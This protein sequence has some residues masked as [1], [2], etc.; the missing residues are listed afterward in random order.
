LGNGTQTEG[1]IVKRQTIM[2]L[3]GLI[4]LA[5]CSL[6]VYK[7]DIRPVYPEL[8]YGVRPTVVDSLTPTFRWQYDMTTPCTYDF[9]IWD[10]GDVTAWGTGSRME[11]RPYIYYK[12]ALTQPEHKIELPLAPDTLYYWSVRT[13]SGNVV[14][15]WATHDSYI[16][17]GVVAAT[18]KNYPFRFRTPQTDKKMP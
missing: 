3:V 13:R 7:G 11:F 9:A 6:P 5:G 2:V 18:A 12:E 15:A 14:S 17:G 8:G 16:W 4:F 1:G 10:V